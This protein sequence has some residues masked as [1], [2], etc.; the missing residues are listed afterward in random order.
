MSGVD[1][2]QLMRYI[3][4]E[5]QIQNLETQNALKNYEVKKKAAED[6][7]LTIQEVENTLKQLNIQTKKEK[8]DVDKMMKNKSIGDIFKTQADYDSQLSQEQEEYLEALNKEEVCKQHFTDLQ[9]QHQDLEREANV[10]LKD[11]D[12]LKKL[13]EERDGL[14]SDIF[15]GEYGSVEENKLE[16]KFDELMDKKQRVSVANYKW[17]NA[18]VLLQHAVNQLAH[19]VRKWSDLDRIPPQQ[20]QVKY[21]AATETRNNLIAA[22]QNVQ[23][24]QRYLNT[25]QFPYCQPC[26]METLSRA[27]N[28][29][30]TDMVDKGRHKHAFTCYEV[31]Y[32][33]AAALLQWFDNVIQGTIQKDL[34]KVTEE[35]KKV[36]KDL[37]AERIKLIRD[38]V[39]ESGGDVGGLTDAD[40][41]IPCNSLKG[42]TDGFS[43]AD[44]Q[45][46]SD[47][48]MD[49]KGIGIVRAA[50]VGDDGNMPDASNDRPMP[51]PTPLPL[52]ELAPL[53]CEDD[54]F[55]DISQLKEQ[56]KK[57]RE[58]FERQQGLN[59]IRQEQGLQEKL[60]ARRHKKKC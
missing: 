15:G 22:V 34:K 53:P 7:A 28:N 55:G 32:K 30:Y 33:R 59:K 39:A 50:P 5:K 47:D 40:S 13:Y 58:E 14:L 25:I 60:A 36:E 35:V 10:L 1:K 48:D 51:A 49:L 43:Q 54:L 4:L 26:E 37:R 31:T 56:Y 3:E 9:K 17:T 46:L 41:D 12:V 19:A 8:D 44:Q 11:A 23:S 42:L 29:I 27:A 21:T 45:K 24:T 16:A 38:K 20:M 6:V 57:D 2:E 52:S 18:R